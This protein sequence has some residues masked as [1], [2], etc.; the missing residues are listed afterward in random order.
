MGLWS[1]FQISAAADLG[2]EAYMELT[3]TQT[4]DMK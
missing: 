1:K 4:T 2:K 3:T